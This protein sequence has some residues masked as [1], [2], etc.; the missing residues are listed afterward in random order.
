MKNALATSA[1]QKRQV[2][3]HIAVSAAFRLLAIVLVSTLL[4]AC[5]RTTKL[6]LE[7]EWFAAPGAQ[8]QMLTI[9]SREQQPFT[10]RR[11]VINGEF[12]VQE[13]SGFQVERFRET[14]LTIGEAAAYSLD[15]SKRIL[16]AD[17]QTDRGTC[18][19]EFNSVE[20][21]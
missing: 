10:I 20:S 11:I 17:I 7:A 3:A 5:G 1:P 6:N 12:T 13:M 21:L 19:Y 9:R 14:T 18:R 2:P 8:K 4:L 15:Y 16:Y